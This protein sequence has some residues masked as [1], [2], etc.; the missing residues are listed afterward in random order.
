[1]AKQKQRGRV[2]APTTVLPSLGRERLSKE[3]LMN[4]AFELSQRQ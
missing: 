1:M 4:G 3:Q 2:S